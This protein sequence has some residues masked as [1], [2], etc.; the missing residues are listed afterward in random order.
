MEYLDPDSNRY[1]LYYFYKFYQSLSDLFWIQSLLQFTT[2]LLKLAHHIF[3]SSQLL[4]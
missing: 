1:L 4:L 3:F 2:E